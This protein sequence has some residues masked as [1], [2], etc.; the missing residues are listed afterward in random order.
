MY[1]TIQV[2]VGEAGLMSLQDDW[3]VPFEYAVICMTEAENG[4]DVY[5]GDRSGNF[6][7]FEQATGILRARMRLVAGTVRS[8]VCF[9]G[10]VYACGAMGRIGEWDAE[11][12][13]KGPERCTSEGED[14]YAGLCAT[15]G[16]SDVMW[17]GDEAKPPTLTPTLAD[18]ATTPPAVCDPTPVVCR[19]GRSTVSTSL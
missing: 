19:T 12:F 13:K 16:E 14:I 5:V 8:I 11:T 7:C 10:K 1:F 9:K 3:S 18:A 17:V 2:R 4:K 6:F 15:V